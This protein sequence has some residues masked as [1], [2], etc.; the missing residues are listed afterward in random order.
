MQ[1]LAEHPHVA[2]DHGVVGRQV[3]QLTPDLDTHSLKYYYVDIHL[4]NADTE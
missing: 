2:A 1:S 4:E 3:Q